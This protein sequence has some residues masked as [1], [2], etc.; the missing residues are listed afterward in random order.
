MNKTPTPVI[1]CRQIYGCE[2]GGDVVPS[3]TW[4]GSDVSLAHSC[5]V[6]GDALLHVLVKHLKLFCRQ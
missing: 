1:V 5:G 2:H 4:R 3:A 6:I